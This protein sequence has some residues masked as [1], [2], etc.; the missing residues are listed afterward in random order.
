MTIP[1]RSP[2]IFSLILSVLF[3]AF[4]L[5]GPGVA[6][7]G[8][9]SGEA[10]ASYRLVFPGG[11]VKVPSLK[12]D[13]YEQKSRLSGTEWKVDVNVSASPL[14]VRESWTLTKKMAKSLSAADREIGRS[15]SG[16]LAGACS[17]DEAVMQVFSF[18]REKWSYVE[19]DDSA[20]EIRD[21][22]SSGE[23]SCLG[24]VRLA[25]D[26]LNRI[27]IPSRAITGIRFPP[28]GEE[29]LLKGGALHAWLEVEVEKGRWVSCDPK[30][31]FG[32]VPQYYIVLKN[33]GPVTREELKA[34]AGGRVVLESN[35]DRLFFDPL[36]SLKPDFWIRPQYDAATQGVLLGKVL[37]VKDLPARGRASLSCGDRVLKCDLWDGNFYFRVA[38]PGIYLLKIEAEE[39]GRGSSRLVELSDLSRKKLVVG[40]GAPE[41]SN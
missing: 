1:S 29:C 8:T 32:F 35:R 30:S 20:L 13:G 24:M 17:R 4:V 39:P 9:V 28:E 10:S 41:I 3:P 5:A 14:R 6:G 34:L 21:L 2:R 23:A 26:F 11:G 19:K 18:I 25:W 22:L 38:S 40:A 27:E 7:D 37:L 33:E 16:K 15:L 31:F 12:N 36:S